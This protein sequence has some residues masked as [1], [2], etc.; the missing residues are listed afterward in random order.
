MMSPTPIPEHDADPREPETPAEA[1][2]EPF[3]DEAPDEAPA[4]PVPAL[5]THRDRPEYHVPDGWQGTGPLPQESAHIRRSVWRLPVA[6]IAFLVGLWTIMYLWP[7]GAGAPQGPRDLTAQFRVLH[8]FFQGEGVTP[9]KG[10][11]AR[12]TEALQARVGRYAV[13][14]DLRAAGLVA[15]GARALNIGGGGM[16][17]I[18]YQDRGGGP[19]VLAVFSPK[20]RVGVPEGSTE[21]TVKG[22]TVWLQDASFAA[23]AYAEA[24]DLDWALI[25]VRDPDALL[26][27]A[28]VLVTG[29]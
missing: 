25:S 20:G 5:R 18:R 10:T 4:A 15:I 3:P 12:I 6:A 1:S 28:E 22:G 19:D 27:V 14:P 11:P 9:F 21:R 13:V 7:H 2:A 24:D 23:I 8:N 29:S 16:G 17:L 26:A